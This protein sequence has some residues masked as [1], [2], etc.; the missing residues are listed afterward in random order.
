MQQANIDILQEMDPAQIFSLTGDTKVQEVIGRLKFMS[1]IRH[2][3]KINVRD[4]FV[5]DNDSVM[6]RFLRTF[7]NVTTYISA[8]EIV[9]SKEAT[10]TFIQGT[11][12]E[13]ITLIAVYHRDHDEFKQSIANIIVENLEASK[14]GIRNLIA[15]YQ[16][17][18]KFISEVEA[19]IQTLEVRILSMKKKGYMPGLTE[20]SFMP[21]VDDFMDTLRGPILFSSPASSP[22]SSPVAAEAEAESESDDDPILLHESSEEE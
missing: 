8:S 15:T 19:V 5:R 17:D 11:V 9:E 3:E 1:K 21:A 2:G 22:A 20:E 13:A 18:R 4:L 14:A 7:K 10:L 16:S 6:Q 12:N